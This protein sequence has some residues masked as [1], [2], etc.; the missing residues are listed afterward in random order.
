MQ[1]KD[2]PLTYFKLSKKV[3]LDHYAMVES[4][5][6]ITS[7][8]S[9]TNS[10][11]TPILEE[12]T[13]AVFSIHFLAELQHV[14]DMSR[15]FYLA[16]AWSEKEILFL[17][18][19]GV[20]SFCVDNK[21]D[22]DIFLSTLE[23]NPSIHVSLF[24]RLRLKE[25]TVRTEKYFVF[26][27]KSKELNQVIAQIH[28]SKLRSQIPTLG[29]HMHRKTQN[30]AEWNYSEDLS[31]ELDNKTLQIISVLNIGGGLP[32]VYANTNRNV[33]EG[34]FKKLRS[35]RVFCNTKNI[36]LMVEPG[37]FISAP[38]LSLHTTIR[39]LYDNTI[40]VDASVYNTDMDALIVPVKLVVRGELSKEEAKEKNARAYAIKG[41]TPCS[42]DLFRY[43]VYYEHPNV[44]DELI[45]ENA[46]AYNFTTTFCD[47]PQIP[48]KVVE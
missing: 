24:L 41:I 5:V 13:S 30:M 37:R 23:K 2:T 43:K 7:Y 31:D 47:L 36:K 11:I 33:L 48:T 38:A 45:F 9:K 8:S 16:Q 28:D 17:F 25:N 46:G 15:V 14:K 22:L 34:I 4:L 39:Q 12:H 19:K 32:S 26:G 1:T 20:R 6:D 40:V 3:A 10:L 42:L 35:L 29:V 44:G 18:E 27:F 21:P